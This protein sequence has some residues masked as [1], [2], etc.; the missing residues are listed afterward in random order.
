MPPFIPGVELNRLFY[1]EA[2]QPILATDFPNLR[3][4]AALIGWGSDV[5][6]FDTPLSRDHGWGLRLTLFVTPD[7]VK[8]YAEPIKHALSHKLPVQVHGYSTHYVYFPEEPHIPHMQ[9]IEG[10]PVTHLVSVANLR[11]NVLDYTGLDLDQPMTP[12]DWLAIP[13]QKL[14]T[15]IAGGVYHSGLGEVDAMRQRLR[16][17][18]H[19]VWL[20]L[21]ACGWVRIGQEEPFV[22]RTGDV[23]DDLGSRIIA[24]RLV[25]DLMRLCLLMEKQYPPYS[26][27]YGTAFSRLACAETLSP[28]F[29]AALSAE[30]WGTRE[31]HLAAAYQIVAEKQNA[32]GLTEPL[33]TEIVSFFGRPYHVIY[34]GRFADA[35]CAKI[36]D[37]DVKRIADTT[38]IGSIDQFSDSTDMLE[39]AAISVRLRQIYT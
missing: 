24:A 34:G 25:R 3:Y 35:L 1:T 36:T 37:P 39:N 27:W 14:R 29:Q 26:K 22:G 15:H 38:M 32:L 4:D 21:L 30:D 23:G 10:G 6:G 11:Q 2:V 17:Y 8:R 13:S 12:A 20:Y 18:P 5:L 16:W 28:I 9:E 7:D 33:S 31:R 19:D